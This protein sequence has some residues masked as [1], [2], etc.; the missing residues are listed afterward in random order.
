[1]GP[2]LRDAIGY[3]L[4][5]YCDQHWRIKKPVDIIQRTCRPAISECFDQS[6][7]KWSRWE[8]RVNLSVL[9]HKPLVD[10]GEP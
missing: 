8:K 4:L 10:S 1:M 9:L 5:A 6:A 7:A 3:D 2:L